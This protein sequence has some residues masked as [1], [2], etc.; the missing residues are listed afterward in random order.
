MEGDKAAEAL[1]SERNGSTRLNKR[2]TITK[3]F[4]DCMT[5]GALGNTI[6]FLVLMGLMKGRSSEQIMTA[7]KTV[8][9]PHILCIAEVLLLMLV[10]GNC[11]HHCCRLQDLA[12]C[13]HHQL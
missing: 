6:I 12:N 1:L 10:P 11:S 8:W 7:I 3:W 4:I 2:N 9:R 5:M 13:I